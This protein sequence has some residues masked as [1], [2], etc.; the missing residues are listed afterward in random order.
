MGRHPQTLLNFVNKLRMCEKTRETFRKSGEDD[1]GIYVR[2]GVTRAGQKNKRI[3]AS[4][5][6]MEDRFIQKIEHKR[7][8]QKID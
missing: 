5:L 8:I 3:E 6:G 4:I 7:S 1:R 2:G